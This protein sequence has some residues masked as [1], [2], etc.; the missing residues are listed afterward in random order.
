MSPR[1][2]IVYGFTSTPIG[3]ALLV[4]SR[5]AL[6]GLYMAD[7]AHTPVVAESWLPDRGQLDHVRRQLDE[8]FTGARARFDVVTRPAGTPFQLAAWSIL[9]EIPYGTTV[10]YGELAGRLGRSSGGRREWT[11]P[12]LHRHSVPPG[13]RLQW[14]SRRLW[15]GN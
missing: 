9:E 15:L 13:D 1:S 3:E 7:H 2:P 11:E 10:T 5:A 6:T 8:Y 12:D 4:G 14:R